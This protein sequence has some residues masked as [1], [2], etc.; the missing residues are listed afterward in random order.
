[1]DL[2]LELLDEVI[3]DGSR[4]KEKILN[5]YSS[6]YRT[7]NKCR[8]A[9]SR[10]NFVFGWGNPYA[11]LVFVGE[12]PGREEDIRGK[13]FVG[14]AGQLLSE[15]LREIGIDRERDVYIANILKCRPPGNRDPRND[16]IR[17]CFPHLKFQL[18][19]ISP[20]IIVALGRFSASVL[21]SKPVERVLSMYRGKVV[22]GILDVNVL[23]T[24][25]P[26]AALR[27]PGL[28]GFIKQDIKKAWEYTFKSS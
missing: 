22:R 6:F 24:Y 14:K 13:P 5:V 9:S 25:H 23:P 19:V 27:N 20:S 16:E 1:M 12:A 18:E 4:D 21:L 17:A 10:T 11:K 2:Y 8:L 3:L 28:R 26:A 7:C 15:I